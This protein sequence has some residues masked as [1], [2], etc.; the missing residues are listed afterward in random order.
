MVRIGNEIDC[1]VDTASSPVLIE[2]KSGRALLVMDI[3]DSSGSPVSLSPG[4][5]GVMAS[6]PAG[7]RPDV[8]CKVAL[9]HEGDRTIE[10]SESDDSAR[11]RRGLPRRGPRGGGRIRAECEPLPFG[12]WDFIIN[13]RTDKGLVK[14]VERGYLEKRTH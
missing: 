1:I 10:E 3:T 2:I 14:I 9:S 4:D 8:P 6:R 11:P 5:V 13:I 7:D 12:L